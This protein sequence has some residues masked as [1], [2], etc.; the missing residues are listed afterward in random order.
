MEIIV[1]II[2]AFDRQ[3]S[4]GNPAGIV[5]DADTL[6]NEQKQAIAKQIGLSETAFVSTVADYR[7]E[8]FTPE[9]Q[10]LIAAMPLSQPSPF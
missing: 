6:N 5:F 9:K 2:S 4:G 3:G 1:K 7:F 10:F 8:F